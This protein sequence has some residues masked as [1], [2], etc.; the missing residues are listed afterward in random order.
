MHARHMGAL[1]LRAQARAFSPSP[2]ALLCAL[3]AHADLLRH[4]LRM[5]HQMHVLATSLGDL[6]MS[7]QLALSVASCAVLRDRLAR[8]ADGL[9]PEHHKRF[10]FDQKVREHVLCPKCTASA[11]LLAQRC[12]LVCVHV[13]TCVCVLVCVCV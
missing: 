8:G 7:G 2:P 4:R 5:L 11:R 13:S 1:V 9:F 10:A 12:R 3:C 6:L